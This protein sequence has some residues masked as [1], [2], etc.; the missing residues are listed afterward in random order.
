MG[1][2]VDFW[3]EMGIKK[4]FFKQDLTKNAPFSFYNGDYHKREGGK[5]TMKFM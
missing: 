1:V 5:C 4:P 3:E 2:F